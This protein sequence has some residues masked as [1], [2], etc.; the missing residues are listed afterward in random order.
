MSC[1]VAAPEVCARDE[2]VSEKARYFEEGCFGECV[3]SVAR[4]RALATFQYRAIGGAAGIPARKEPPR[5]LATI[6]LMR[7]ERA[8]LLRTARV[9]ELT[10]C[11]AFDLANPL[12]GH[13]EL[14]ANFFE[15]VIRDR[16][17]T[18]A[19]SQHLRFAR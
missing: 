13:V 19:H 12:A 1:S 11:L 6:T 10:H 3:G 8:Q 9:D 2:A 4:N 18:K 17:D 7:Q 16:I 14:L 15:R 5:R